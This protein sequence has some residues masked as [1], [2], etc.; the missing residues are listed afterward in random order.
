VKREGE[1]R[2]ES[3]LADREQARRRSN[4]GRNGG[5]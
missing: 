2:G 4:W 3:R 5:S 1:G